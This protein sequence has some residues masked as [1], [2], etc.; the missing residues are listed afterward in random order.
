MHTT[1][2]TTGNGRF[3]AGFGVAI[4]LLL[5]FP[6]GCD[7]CADAEVSRT[8]SPD[9]RVDAVLAERNCGAASSFAYRVFLAPRG[10]KIANNP[11]FVAD[12]V[13]NLN[14]RWEN[15][16]QLVITYSQANIHGFVNYW[17]MPEGTGNDPYAFHEVRIR[18]M[19]QN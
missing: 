3:F 5:M 13:S 19:Q 1:G 7:D 17:S 16:H 6:A 9:G 10:Q 12:H 18:E 14:I 11:L 2:F 4:A 8:T 15:P